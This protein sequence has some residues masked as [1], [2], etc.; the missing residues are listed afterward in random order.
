MLSSFF[1]NSYLQVV[2]EEALDETAR[3]N[4]KNAEVLS[5]IR[6]A[7]YMVMLANAYTEEHTTHHI[8]QHSKI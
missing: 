8:V 4:M 7:D 1:L 2:F 5:N 3:G 6:Y